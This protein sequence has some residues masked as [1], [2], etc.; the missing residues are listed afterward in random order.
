MLIKSRSDGKIYNPQKNEWVSNGM[1]NRNEINNQFE[2]PPMGPVIHIDFIK[3]YEGHSTNKMIYENENNNCINF[4]K[5]YYEERLP[6]LLSLNNRNEYNEIIKLGKL[7]LKRANNDKEI[8]EE[9]YNNNLKLYNDFI[10]MYKNSKKMDDVPKE[11]R[12]NMTRIFPCRYKTRDM[13]LGIYQSIQWNIYRMKNQMKNND[14]SESPIGKQKIRSLLKDKLYIDELIR[15][16]IFTKEDLYYK[17]FKNEN[18]FEDLQNL[19]NEYEIQF[20]QYV[21]DNYPNEV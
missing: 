16:K 5:F 12:I 17:M 4:Y 2:T 7:L 20:K 18:V 8:T 9:T 10:E 14:F 6:Y 21:K 1:L 15:E 13:T 11:H 19:Y 3:D